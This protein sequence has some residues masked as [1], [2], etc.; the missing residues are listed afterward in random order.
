MSRG[1]V[2][3][4]AGIALILSAGISWLFYRHVAGMVVAVV[5]GPVMYNLKKQENIG[6]RQER[7]RSQFK[8]C[9]RVV[10]ASMQVGYSVE[11]AFLEAQKELEQLLGRQADMCRELLQMNQQIRLNVPIE[12]LLEKLAYRS[13]VEEIFSFGQVFGYAK[14]SG[15]DFQRI[16]QD[17]TERIS[18]KAE[19]EQEIGTMI[20]G[21][22][23]EQRIMN[24]IP[25]GIL[26][27]INWTSPEF[28]KM[29]YEGVLGRL[30]MTICLLV[31]GGA[32]LLSQKIVDI[33]I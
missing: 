13:G 7:L 23:I 4:C 33:R 32:Y 5:L 25:L 30:C 8:E 9:I 3:K 20:A 1:D 22:R 19:L 17:T 26:F 15:G 10:T 6:K 21:K 11:H 24:V 14:R 31:Y 12:G 18:E 29:M 2:A 16:L 27:L 28:L